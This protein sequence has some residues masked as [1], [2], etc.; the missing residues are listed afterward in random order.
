MNLRVPLLWLKDP[1]L[2]LIASRVLFHLEKIIFES[3]IAINFRRETRQSP[4]LNQS[5]KSDGSSL[6]S[7]SVARLDDFFH[8]PEYF[9]RFFEMGSSYLVEG[10]PTREE[11]QIPVV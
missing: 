8:F 10:L 3:K 11:G 6:G 2:N 9:G 1:N 7:R 4:N 5:P